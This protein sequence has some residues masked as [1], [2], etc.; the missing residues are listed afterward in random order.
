M[1]QVKPW[2]VV[3]ITA[4]LTLAGLVFSAGTSTADDEVVAR[5]TMIDINGNKIGRATFVSKKDGVRAR[6]DITIDNAVTA[7]PSNFH[8][9]HIHANAADAGCVAKPRNTTPTEWF[10]E[11][12]GHWDD[13]THAHGAHHGD[14]PSLLRKSDGSAHLEFIVDEYLVSQLPG[15]TLIVHFGADDFGKHPTI[16]T[17]ATTG[18]AGPRYACGLIQAAHDD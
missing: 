4:M 1:K 18:N 13:G 7:N 17:S 14:H 2:V 12:G 15:R 8:G 5:A 3:T 6:L 16:G 9:F 10:T 11:V